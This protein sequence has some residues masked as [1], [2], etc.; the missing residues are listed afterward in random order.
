MKT[1]EMPAGEEI[2][3]FKHN[4]THEVTYDTLLE[5]QRQQLHRIIAAV[6][7]EIQPD[8][9]SLVA[10]HAFKGADWEKALRYL[11]L[12]GQLARNLF[13]NKEA[14]THLQR[15]QQAAK[16]LPAKATR[17]ARLEIIILL[18]RNFG[19]TRPL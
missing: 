1:V 12:A 18:G 11:L 9:A 3:A 10:Y 7:E 19:A 8:D 5:Q 2:Y 4:I 15:A 16:K 13:A 6:T 17:A 14:I